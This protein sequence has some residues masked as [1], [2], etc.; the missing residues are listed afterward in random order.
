MFNEHYFGQFMQETIVRNEPVKI[1]QNQIPEGC[2]IAL[3]TTSNGNLL[4]FAFSFRKQ[5]QGEVWSR[6]YWHTKPTETDPVGTEAKK[7]PHSLK[8]Q[9]K[10]QN[11]ILTWQGYW[12]FQ[13]RNF[14]QLWLIS[15]GIEH[16]VGSMQEQMGNAGRDR[17]I[18]SRNQKEMPVSKNIITEMKNALMDLFVD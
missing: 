10:H 6:T 4:I 5:P 12:N 1:N 8:R 9:S 17:E 18:L 3:N 13:T 2:K 14:K 16:T 11:Q 15:E 7:K